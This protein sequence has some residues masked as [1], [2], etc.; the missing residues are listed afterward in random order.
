MQEY[1]SRYLARIPPA[2][3]TLR[4]QPAFLMILRALA[5]AGPAGIIVCLTPALISDILD[6]ILARR[7]SVDSAAMRRY[8]STAAAV[9]YLS[10]VNTMCAR[11]YDV[12]T[13]WHAYR[14]RRQVIGDR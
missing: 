11:R 8:D 9:F 7:F 6:G 4:V 12:P 3:T 2:L 5:K 10:A 1:V 14:I 13:A